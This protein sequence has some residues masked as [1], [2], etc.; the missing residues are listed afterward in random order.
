MYYLTKNIDFIQCFKTKSFKFL[1]RLS[2][3]YPPKT[4]Q[5]LFLTTMNAK[6]NVS[7]E[8]YY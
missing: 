3:K 2:N 4:L 5:F 8:N 6:K 1:Q 7:K